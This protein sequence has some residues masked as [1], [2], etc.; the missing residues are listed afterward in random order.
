MLWMGASTLVAFVTGTLLTAIFS[1]IRYRMLLG[2]P[3]LAA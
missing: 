3:K 1:F 2:D